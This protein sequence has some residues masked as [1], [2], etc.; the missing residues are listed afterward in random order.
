MCTVGGGGADK[1]VFKAVAKGEKRAGGIKAEQ[2]LETG[3]SKRVM[4]GRE[5]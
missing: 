5:K 3:K 2:V 4:S 1:K